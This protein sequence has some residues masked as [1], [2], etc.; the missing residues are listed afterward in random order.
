MREHKNKSGIYCITNKVNGKKYIGKTKCFYRR[1][2]QYVSDVRSSNSNRINDYLLNSFNKYGFD[3]FTFE[4]IE[5]CSVE[6]CSEKEL[7]WILKLN[8]TDKEI[9]YNLRLD[10]S[11]GMITHEMTS[12]K[13]SD[14]LRNEWEN[15]V[16]KDHGEK[17]KASWEFRDREEQSKLMSK[18]LTKY[19]YDLYY[20]DHEEVDVLYKQLRDRGLAAVIGTF[21]RRKVSEAKCKGVKVVR[22]KLN[23]C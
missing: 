12:K 3:S 22:R 11:T 8:T 6:E 17:L 14:R 9:G 20:D 1:Y 2:C 7:Y 4:V 16:R 23:E 19:V 5:F 21:H 13:I 15:G 10:S 18:T